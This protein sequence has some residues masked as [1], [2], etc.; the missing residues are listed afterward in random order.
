VV[1]TA[2][3]EPG[4]NPAD[5]LAVIENEL[6]RYGGL[7]DRPRLVALNKVDVPDGREIAGMVEDDLREQG[8]R[9]FL[10]SAASGE[11][12]R[13]LSF[14]MAEI[15]AAARAARP[16]VAA[17]RIVLRPESADGGDE[18]TVT[19]TDLSDGRGWHVRGTKPERW[20]RQTDFSNDEAVGYLAD[21]LARL[22]VEDELKRRGAQ[23]GAAVTIGDVTFD[24]EPTGGIDESEYLPT[25]RGEDER[26]AEST[27]TRAEERLAAK[28]ARRAPAA[29]D[30]W[31]ED[32]E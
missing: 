15:V 27:R 16:V 12:L 2:S 21:R 5:D 19:A 24:W 1:D 6:S 30:D 3:I 25:R 18:F 26:L 23:A 9:V 7:E 8:L 10:V 31:P 13:E 20:V 22:G 17:T 11:G 28:R 32:E 14:A 29:A 4:R